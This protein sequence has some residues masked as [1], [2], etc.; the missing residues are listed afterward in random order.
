MALMIIGCNVIL[1]TWKIIKTNYSSYCCREGKEWAANER[2]KIINRLNVLSF[3][4]KTARIC[5]LK[6]MNSPVNYPSC[7]AVNFIRSC[8]R[9][10]SKRSRNKHLQPFQRAH[11]SHFVLNDKRNMTKYKSRD[12]CTSVCFFAV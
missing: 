8:Q 1:F 12:L 9:N 6:F 2:G 7:L 11:R 5:L 10:L 3:L 4:F